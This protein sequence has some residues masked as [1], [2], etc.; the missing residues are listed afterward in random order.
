[1]VGFRCGWLSVFPPSG[2]PARA[3]FQAEKLS[4]SSENRQRVWDATTA[5]QP[6]DARTRGSKNT[7]FRDDLRLFEDVRP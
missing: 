7:K 1:M 4:F 3:G 6:C 2:I 5:C